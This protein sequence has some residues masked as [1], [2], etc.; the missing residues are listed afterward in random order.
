M[1][2]THFD[3][4]SCSVARTLNII[5]EWWT[6]LILRDIFFGIRRFDVLR[7]HLGISRKVLTAR[8]NTLIE[9]KILER[10]QYQQNPERYE[11]QLTERGHDLFP[12]IV[13][14]MVWGDKWIFEATPPVQLVDRKTKDLIK[15]A[16]VS[17]DTGQEIRYENV[18]ARLASEKFSKEWQRLLKAISENSS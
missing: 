6:L 10:V 1:Q 4:M 14:L 16:L 5:G 7:K 13:T 15:P 2:R 18:Q 12:V 9:N 11:Y 17:I 3:N 8:L